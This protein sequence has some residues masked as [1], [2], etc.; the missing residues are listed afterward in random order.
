MNHK[1]DKNVTPDQLN[2]VFELVEDSLRAENILLPVEDSHY[3]DEE[4]VLKLPEHLCE[5]MFV[6]QRGKE[7]LENGLN[8]HTASRSDE[9]I[10]NQLAQA[11]RNGNQIPAEVLDRM[12]EDRNLAER[13]S[14]SSE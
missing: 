3:K 14:N 10:E 2:H 5:P 6:L 4:E 12:H 8:G 11:A 7:V 1:K 9:F 13:K